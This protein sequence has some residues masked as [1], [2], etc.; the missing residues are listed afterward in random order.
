VCGE[1][2][3]ESAYGFVRKGIKEEGVRLRLLT[4]NKQNYDP[5]LEEWEVTRSR[6]MPLAILMSLVVL[7][8]I[9]WNCGSMDSTRLIMM[10][11]PAI[12]S[13]DG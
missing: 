2:P 13:P 5:P 10:R 8:M 11:A 1:L 3:S 7:L 9:A 4:I 6:T 12:A